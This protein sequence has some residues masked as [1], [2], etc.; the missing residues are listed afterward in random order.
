LHLIFQSA[1]ELL[2]NLRR[3]AIAC[4]VQNAFLF[5]LLEIIL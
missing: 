3:N 2:R 5:F 1:R 4:F